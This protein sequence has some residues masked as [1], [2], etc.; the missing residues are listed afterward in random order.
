[1]KI[2]VTGYH[3]AGTHQAA[4]Y[5][6]T[7]NGVD[8]Y[9]ENRIRWDSLEAAFMLADGLSPKWSEEG[10]LTGVSDSRLKRKGFVLQCPGL[11]H[12]VLELSKVGNVYWCSRAMV[13]VITSMKNAGI[14]EMAWHLM[15]GFHDRFPD[16]PIWPTL[17]YDGSQDIH[18][19]FVRYYKLLIQVK[20][21]FY[22]T[23][24]KD[25]AEKI[26]MEQMPYYDKGK[27]LTTVKPLKR[28]EYEAVR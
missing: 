12:N 23:R 20:Q 15:K 27:A 24:F 1:M 8:L 11:A 19:G 3:R 4:E 7:K 21:Y 26:V 5:L 13:D 6:A 14:N 16:D 28:R 22:E 2:F 18:D 10:K 17:S 9:Y 25:V